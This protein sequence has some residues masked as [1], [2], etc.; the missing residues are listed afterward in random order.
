MEQL[1]S[2][3]MIRVGDT[4]RSSSGRWLIVRK[5]EDDEADRDKTFV[6]YVGGSRD[7]FCKRHTVTKEVKNADSRGN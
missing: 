3:R 7:R 6:W 1:I 5:V 2:V 4:I